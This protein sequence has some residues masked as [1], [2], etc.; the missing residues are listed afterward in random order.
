MIDETDP[1]LLSPPPRRRGR[2]KRE[3][4]S[5]RR[6]SILE[7]AIRLFAEQG[8]DATSMS[9]V[10][11]SAGVTE[12]LVRHYF[13]GRDGL[14]AATTEAVMADLRAHYRKAANAAVDSP[15]GVLIKRLAE[16][17]AGTFLPRPWLLAYLAKLFASNLSAA[18]DAFAEYFTMVRAFVERVAARSAPESVVDVFW[19]TAHLVFVQIGPAYLRRRLEALLGRDIYD[20]DIAERRQRQ[21]SAIFNHGLSPQD[22]KEP[23]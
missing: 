19:L 5:N 12:G 8:M 2:P 23:S 10:A 1:A 21:T 4:A 11:V 7:Q 6:E 3:D 22:A 20:A 9:Q 17:D 15:G 13:G 14:L 18:D 16:V